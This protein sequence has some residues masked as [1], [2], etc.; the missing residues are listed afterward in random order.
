MFTEFIGG[1]LFI[2]GFLTRP[3]AIPVTINMVVATLSMMP[4]GFIMGFAD[5]PFSILVSSIIILLAGPMDY[6]LDAILFRPT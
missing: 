6:S 2:I 5:F 1:F 4:H 3:I